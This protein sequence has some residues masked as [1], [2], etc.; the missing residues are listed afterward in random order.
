MSMESI[1]MTSG[2]YF[3]SLKVVHLALVVGVVFFALTSILLQFAGFGTLGPDVDKILVLVVPIIAL[4][5]SYTSNFI[6]RKKLSEIKKKSSLKEKME[7][8]RSAFIIRLALIE[9]PS[10]LTV[11]A[12]LLTGNYLFLGIVVALLIVFFIYSP[13]QS[14]FIAELELTK[15]ESDM[16]NNPETVIV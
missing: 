6:F 12:Y 14:K 16:I 8:Y 1:K 5:G 7:E 13:N 10:F 4:I 11:V 9:A 2:E 3:K 15:S